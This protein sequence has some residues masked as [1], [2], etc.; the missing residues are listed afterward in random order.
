MA[1]SHQ[2]KGMGT[3]ENSIARNS[4]EMVEI[5]EETRHS[6][7]NGQNFRSNNYNGQNSRGR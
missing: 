1:Q 6:N 5:S 2:R 7:N 4:I 3:K